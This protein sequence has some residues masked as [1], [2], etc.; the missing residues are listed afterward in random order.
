MS[1]AAILGLLRQGSE[2]YAARISQ[3]LRFDLPGLRYYFQPDPYRRQETRVSAMLRVITVIGTLIAVQPL[4]DGPARAGDEIS[5]FDPKSNSMRGLFVLRLPF[6]G[7]TS[8]FEPRVGFDFHMEQNSDRDYR[9]AG[10]DPRTGRRIPE[11]DASRM[12]TW[13]FEQPDIALPDD[14]PGEPKNKRADRQLWHAS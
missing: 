14:R 4:L 10:Q 11:I 1:I 2:S 6:G 5:P 7:A 9:R 8:S 13:T 12:R 3:P